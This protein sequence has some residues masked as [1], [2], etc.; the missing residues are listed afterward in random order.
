MGMNRA[1]LLTS[2]SCLST[3]LLL[4]GCW[5]GDKYYEDVNCPLRGDAYFVEFDQDHSGR[6][7][8]IPTAYKPACSTRARP[9]DSGIIETSLFVKYP[10]LA[11][12]GISRFE[13][14]REGDL[15][16]R[17]SKNYER[18]ADANTTSADINAYVQA[19]VDYKDGQNQNHFAPV[20]TLGQGMAVQRGLSSGSGDVYFD[21]DP[22][23]GL[24]SSL[25]LCGASGRCEANGVTRDGAYHFS[26][27]WMGGIDP[28]DFPRLYADIQSFVE[29]LRR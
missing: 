19:N 25:T 9:R 29:S 18:A 12:A 27:V 21:R 28:Q 15:Y 6:A 11:P 8:Q 14:M 17:I 22:A 10:S 24:S 16:L 23:T 20:E 4:P 26:Y 3:L 5:M 7:V 2:L 1:H 13:D